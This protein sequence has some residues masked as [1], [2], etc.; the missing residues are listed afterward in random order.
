MILVYLL[1]ECRNAAAPS[2]CPSSRKFWHSGILKAILETPICSRLVRNLSESWRN[3]SVEASLMPDVAIK[4][5]PTP[6]RCFLDLAFEVQV[7]PFRSLRQI[8]EENEAVNNNV[9]FWETFWEFVCK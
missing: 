5:F 7:N 3:E 9:T 4:S 6:T 1:Q 8:K 2:Q